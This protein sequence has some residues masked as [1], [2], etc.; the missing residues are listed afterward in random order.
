MKNLLE[1]KVL[2]KVEKLIA[3][4]KVAQK[5]VDRRINKFQKAKAEVKAKVHQSFQ[6]KKIMRMKI[7]N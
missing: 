5:K 6:Q 1:I 4:V 7:K 3:V 2:I